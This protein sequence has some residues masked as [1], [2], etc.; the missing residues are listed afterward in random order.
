MA[1]KGSPSHEVFVNSQTEK[2][3]HQRGL[4]IRIAALVTIS[5]AGSWTLSAQSGR[6]GTSGE[7]DRAGF[8]IYDVSLFSGFS[9][10]RAP[11]FDQVT[12]TVLPDTTFN[13]FSGGI[14]TSVGW[15]SRKSEVSHFY[16]RYSPSYY[17]QSSSGGFLRSHFSPQQTLDLNWDRKL[18]AKWTAAFS[19]SGSL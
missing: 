13:A 16:I 1:H 15:R 18:G 14:S 11:G 10:T 7:W 8:G 5:L 3:H 6:P 9:S 19:L 12:N 17:Y 2:P 4:R